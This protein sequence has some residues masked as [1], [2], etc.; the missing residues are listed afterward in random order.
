[1]QFTMIQR[2]LSLLCTSNE[3]RTPNEYTFN[4]SGDLCQMSTQ[5]SFLSKQG[6]SVRQSNVYPVLKEEDVPRALKLIYDLNVEGWW[7]YKD[8]YIKH[9][10]CTS[11]DFQKKLEDQV[12]RSKNDY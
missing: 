5:G 9:A 6:F 8:R 3:A 2:V 10:I 11:E 12:T 1:M 4:L 7:H